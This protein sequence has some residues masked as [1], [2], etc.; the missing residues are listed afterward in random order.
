MRFILSTLIF[1]YILSF[2]SLAFANEWTYMIQNSEQIALVEITKGGTY[3]VL[4]KPLKVYKGELP[5]SIKTTA[6]AESHDFRIVDSV[7]TGEQYLVFFHKNAKVWTSGIGY[8]IIKE[9][10]VHCDMT[11]IE[12]PK[13]MGDEYAAIPLKDMETMLNAAISRKIPTQKWINQRLQNIQ[14]EPSELGQNLSM[15]LVAGYKEWIPTL[16]TL[17]ANATYQT[18]VMLAQYIIELDKPKTLKAIT[19]LALNPNSNIFD[20]NAFMLKLR[21]KPDAFVEPILVD[22]LNTLYT[23]GDTLYYKGNTIIK[24]SPLPHFLK[25]LYRKSEHPKTHPIL[26]KLL[27][28]HYLYHPR[29][30][31]SINHIIEIFELH[32]N[33]SYLP[34]LKETI[35]DL[36]CPNQLSICFGFSYFKNKSSIPVLKQYIKKV[37]A[38]DYDN[39]KDPDFPDYPLLFRPPSFL[40]GTYTAIDAISKL[41][42]SNENEYFIKLFKELDT[43]HTKLLS[44]GFGNDWKSK[45]LNSSFAKHQVKQAKAPIFNSFFEWTGFHKDF[46]KHPEL[47]HVKANLEDS[48]TNSAKTLFPNLKDLTIKVLVFLDNRL[49]IATK[50]ATPEY[51]VALAFKFPY[52]SNETEKEK[53]IYEEIS[54]KIH[55][56]LG[57]PKDRIIRLNSRDAS[58]LVHE[59]QFEDD[60]WKGFDISFYT[61]LRTFP[62]KEDADFLDLISNNRVFQQSW[63]KG[64]LEQAVKDIRDKLK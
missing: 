45:I 15:L 42:G 24:S 57:I 56:K 20:N 51:K 19:T 28:D 27:K 4:M 63:S 16:D 44:N 47:F 30:R 13:Y 7:L 6:F 8:Y 9:E 32:K 64:A 61:Y 48:L 33:K 35:L 62:S 59:S 5:K 43:I 49:E 17:V 12:S 55:N 21:Q 46:A 3:E 60:I 52:P 26:L 54:I 41:G 22:Y 18:G 31:N 2:S 39:Y 50:G 34:I 37:L 36:S 11:Y 53:V 58:P 38:F 23:S 1:V 29:P 40:D 14:Q 10:Q 25:M